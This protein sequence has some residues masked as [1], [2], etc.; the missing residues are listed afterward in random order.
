M[1]FAQHLS[2]RGS[3]NKVDL[4]KDLCLIPEHN[5]GSLVGKFGSTRSNVPPQ[6]GRELLG[7]FLTFFPLCFLMLP[8]PPADRFAH[9]RPASEPFP[10]HNAAWELA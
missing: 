2:K 10:G 1:W 4:L 8:L 6:H 5:W 3:S 7:Q 9:P